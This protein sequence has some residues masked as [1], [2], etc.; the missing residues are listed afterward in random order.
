MDNRTQVTEFILLGFIGN[1]WLQKLLFVIFLFAYLITL[2]GNVMIILAIRA[3]AHLHIPMYVFLSY[4]ALLDIA[5]S[6]VTVPKMLQ[7]FLSERKAI[8]IQHCFTQVFFIMCLSVGEGLLLS[9]MAYDRF[10]AVCH[11]LHYTV[12][13]RKEVCAV[14][15]GSALFIGFLYALLNTLLLK[16][17]QFCGTNA[18][19][20]FSCEAPQLFKLS[21]SNTFA[22]QMVIFTLGSLLGMGALL[23]ILASYSLI[24]S[25]VLKIQS[26]EGKRKAFS[27]CTSHMIVVLLYYGTIFFRYL[28]PTSKDTGN[29]EIAPS[30]V[31]FIATPMLNP[32]IYSLRNQEVKRAFV[33]IIQ[34]RQQ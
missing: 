28:K 23:I 26:M 11:P 24:I 14:L 20:H 34:S 4:L 3:E 16:T 30:I 19:H 17:L 15:I 12:M 22:N 29:Q 18:I 31:Y 27:T 1:P 33:K 13:M 5:F 32:I 6:S 10:I 9:V 8:S 21:C 7:D 25:S 2:I